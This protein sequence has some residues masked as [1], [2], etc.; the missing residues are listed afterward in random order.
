[1]QA[2]TYGPQAGGGGY[3]LAP[4][5]GPHAD[6]LEHVVAQGEAHHVPREEVQ[7][8]L[9]AVAAENF[10]YVIEHPRCATL[11]RPDQIADFRARIDARARKAELLGTLESKLPGQARLALDAWGRFAQE[12]DRFARGEATFVELERV[13]V[14]AGPPP[15][16]PGGRVIPAGRWQLM[17]GG[18]YARFG[19][20]H[21][22]TGTVE[23]Y[24]PH[25]FLSERDELDRPTH[26]LNRD[27]G[28]KVVFEYYAEPRSVPHP[29]AAHLRAYPFRKLTITLPGAQLPSG[30]DTPIEIKGTGHILVGP[31][32]PKQGSL[33]TPRPPAGW[34][35]VSWD[36][37]L[38]RRVRE[39]DRDLAREVTA[40][41]AGRTGKEVGMHFLGDVA[42][43]W[44]PTVATWAER[45]VAGG[46]TVLT[47][48]D[49]NASEFDQARSVIDA[50]DKLP[51]TEIFAIPLA[52][53]QSILKWNLDIGKSIIAALEGEVESGGK[54]KPLKRKRAAVGVPGNRN[55]QRQGAI[56]IFG[57]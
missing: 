20:S 53:V 6:L 5:K 28:F 24:R 47:L 9:W 21:Y 29:K 12:F 31:L 39:V 19:T 35:N 51:G 57:D 13:A 16:D 45:G 55:S 32:V 46:R 23:F 10:D 38:E 49:R 1:M 3:L 30:K 42:G 4:L 50:A 18:Y 15:D 36:E 54:E 40:G 56:S 2:A 37:E 14:L 7:A 11:L 25:R 33:E 44:A 26:L 41:Q 43:D 22:A 48:A 17:P 27:T 52:L 34:S 8:I